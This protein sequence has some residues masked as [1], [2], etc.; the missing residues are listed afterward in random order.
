MP[1]AFP[2]GLVTFADGSGRTDDHHAERPGRAGRSGPDH[3]ASTTT[4]DLE[5][6][7]A[8]GRRLPQGWQGASAHGRAFRERPKPRSGLSM[9][10]QPSAS[11]RVVVARSTSPRGPSGVVRACMLA[12]RSR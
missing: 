2:L 8:S 5:P 10:R 6:A 9:P 12:R 1:R 7:E 3:A 4:S 11:M